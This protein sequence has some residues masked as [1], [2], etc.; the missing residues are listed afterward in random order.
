[1]KIFY[2][3]LTSKGCD[4]ISDWHR[5]YS[6]PTA[7]LSVC[8]LFDAA[9]HAATVAGLDN[10]HTATIT[11]IVD[12]TPITLSLEYAWFDVTLEDEDY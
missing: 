3:R 5:H 11:M 10:E 7:D 2:Y 12:G 8:R 1:M 6:T 9:E 4:A